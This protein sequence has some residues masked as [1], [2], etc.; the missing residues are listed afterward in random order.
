MAKVEYAFS[1]KLQKNMTA[2]E[3]HEACRDGELDDKTAFKCCS[4][5]CS[6]RITCVN[7]DKSPWQMRVREH[8]KVY[9]EHS[10]NCTEIMRSHN[11]DVKKKRRELNEAPRIREDIIFHI[12]RPKR[13]SET[14]INGKNDDG[15]AQT[16]QTTSVRRT[17][18]AGKDSERLQRKSNLYLLSTLMRK[19]IHA[20]KNNDLNGLKVS[21]E[22]F[23]KTYEYSL[24]TLFN[25]ISAVSINKEEAWKTKVFYGKAIIR[26]NSKNEYWI[27]FSYK[28]NNSDLDVKC[29]IRKEIIDNSHNKK[30]SVNNIEN[31]LNKEA[32]CFLLGSVNITQKILYIN[33]QSLDHIACSFDD[34]K[35]MSDLM[36][37]E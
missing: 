27:N 34:V 17:S 22:L 21:L 28:F 16:S 31:F 24:G 1:L 32:Y 3:A 12:K 33:V 7:M 19:Y 20:K 18:T 29:S 6:A 26:K 8:F 2:S 35:K 11:T 4:E 9:G 10:V 5:E 36:E 30:G 14:K 37:D 25:E 13:H 15:R 23:G